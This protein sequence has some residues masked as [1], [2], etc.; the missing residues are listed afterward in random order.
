MF[1]NASFFPYRSVS[2]CGYLQ[3]HVFKEND[4]ATE[5]GSYLNNTTK[6]N[7]NMSYYTLPAFK[8]EFGT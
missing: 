8:I 3:R 5:N 6:E 7:G 2:Y 4:A 1:I